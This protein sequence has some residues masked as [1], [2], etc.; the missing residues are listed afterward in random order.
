MRNGYMLLEDTRPKRLTVS[1]SSKIKK[2][3]ADIYKGNY[4]L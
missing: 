4:I 2:S 3:I 1:V